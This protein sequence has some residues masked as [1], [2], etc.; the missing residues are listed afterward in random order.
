[1]TAPRCRIALGE[2]RTLEQN[3]KDAKNQI[4]ELVRKGVLQQS[5]RGDVSSELGWIAPQATREPQ[6]EET[7]VCLLRPEV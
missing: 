7:Q 6:F 2:E 3:K 4:Q 5:D 1:M